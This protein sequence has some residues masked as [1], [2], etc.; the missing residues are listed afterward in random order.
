MIVCHHYT[1][2]L[3]KGTDLSNFGKSHKTLQGRDQ[4]N[5][6][7]NTNTLVGTAVSH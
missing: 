6:G 3:G 1:K 5:Y 7:V 2:E 4:R